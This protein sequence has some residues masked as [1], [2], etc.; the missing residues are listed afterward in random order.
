MPTLENC[1]A[2]AKLKELLSRRE[3]F[4]VIGVTMRAETASIVMIYGQG[5][6]I[7]NSSFPHPANCM[8]KAFDNLP[9]P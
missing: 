5:S 8:R 4:G 7:S 3:A 1:D 6:Q 9:Y 2:I